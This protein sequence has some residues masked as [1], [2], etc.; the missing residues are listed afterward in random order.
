[1][2]LSGSKTEKNLLKTF[3][4]EARTLTKY[5]LFAEK[6]LEDGLN[7]V[8]EDFLEIA[9]EEFGHAREA[10]RRYLK[11]VKTTN[12]NLINAIKD[13]DEDGNLYKRFEKEALEEGF[14][15]IANFY[16]QLIDVEKQHSKAFKEAKYDVKDHDMDRALFK[17]LN[18]GNIVE[19][20]EMPEYCKL[21]RHSKDHI[22]IIKDH[23]DYDDYDD[24]DSDDHRY[25]NP[26]RRRR[27][28]PYY[29]PNN[30]W[31]P[32]FHYPYWF[33]GGYYRKDTNEDDMKFDDSIFWG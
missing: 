15:D 14:E 2:N 25:S 27:R 4:N 32:Y 18:C 29:R 28:R 33:H 19:S 9:K 31:Y 22:H 6:A 11:L 30:W 7:D 21:C 26:R 24:D 1:M 16:K 5:S 20:K 10:F 12:E 8:A 3:A 23:D 13:E 17:C